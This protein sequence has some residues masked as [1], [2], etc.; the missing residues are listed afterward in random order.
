M[1][2]LRG[3]GGAFRRYQGLYYEALA[4][5]SQ[6]GFDAHRITITAPDG[7]EYHDVVWVEEETRIRLEKAAKHAL[8]A[9]R[10]LLGE[11]GGEAL[12]A[13]LAGNVIGI[14]HNEPVHDVPATRSRE[15][16]D[17]R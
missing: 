13:L 10:E 15:A 1:T 11:R 12:L 9:A 3:I 17:A 6:A 16:R 2:E 7:R 4:R 8:E 5:N 14:G